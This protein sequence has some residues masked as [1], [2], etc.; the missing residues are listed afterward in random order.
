MAATEAI[1][2]IERAKRMDAA[3]RS[4]MNA[5]NE[6]EVNRPYNKLAN[7][8]KYGIVA[9]LIV[10]IYQF[11]LN[12]AE[13]GINI[14]WGLVGFFLMLPVFWYALRDLKNH[15]A[16]GEFFKNA[17]I[18]SM[19]ISVFA[20]LVTVLIGV[21]GYA[22]GTGDAPEVMSVEGINPGQLMANSV[23]QLVIGIV[24]GNTI[25]FI[26]MQGMKTDVPAD[27]FIEKQS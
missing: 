23:F 1:D 26:L 24:I 2:P 9:G 4:E 12:A 7:G 13:D 27:E 6:R 16:A 18:L 19:Y 10:G 11:F 21:I 5:A 22:I 17:A 20:G 15:Y 14:G 25:G 3:K 8:I